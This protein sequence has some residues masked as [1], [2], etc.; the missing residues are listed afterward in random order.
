MKVCIDAGHG[1]TD[2]GAAAGKPSPLV[3][4]DFTLALARALEAACVGRGHRVLMT[5]RSDRTLSLLARAA[6]ANRFRAE[7]IVSL[8]ANAASDPRAQGMEVFHFPG[9]TVGARAARA[10]LAAMLAAF[11]GHTD[12]GVKAARFVV[13]RETRMPAILVEAEF[14][15]HPVQ[16]RFLRRRSTHRGLARAIAAG[17][18]AALRPAAR[19]ARRSRSVRPARRRR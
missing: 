7:V 18:E 14:L 6:F 3:E 10:V 15:T 5:R 9:S 4:K 11:P 17:L 16:R 8:H 12:R 19:R 1:G 13:L 2:P